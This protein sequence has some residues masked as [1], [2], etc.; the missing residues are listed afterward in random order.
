MTLFDPIAD[1][2]PNYYKLKATILTITRTTKLLSLFFENS[3]LRSKINNS[4][5][6]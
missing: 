2:R 1:L 3:K 4:Q 6:I 5:V